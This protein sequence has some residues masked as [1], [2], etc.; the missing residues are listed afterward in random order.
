MKKTPLIFIVV[1]I[2]AAAFVLIVYQVKTMSGSGTIEEQGETSPAITAAYK[3]HCARC[4]GASGE[5]F[6]DKPHIQNNGRTVEEIKDI[7]Q[8][9][10]DNMPAFSLIK[11]PILTD[12]AKFVSRL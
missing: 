10:L 6:G 3:N 9:G 2:A 1:V 11:D 5:G 8:N 4:H 7:I 12:L